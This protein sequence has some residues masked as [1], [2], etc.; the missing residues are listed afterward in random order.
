MVSTQQI[1]FP[2]VARSQL[3]GRLQIPDSTAC[4]LTVWPKGKYL[5]HVARAHDRL[6]YFEMT[7]NCHL[8][9]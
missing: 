5:G 8:S 3:P 6:E 2:Y 7:V 4:V 1:M 9:K